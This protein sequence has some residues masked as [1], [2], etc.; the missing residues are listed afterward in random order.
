MSYILSKYNCFKIYDNTVV[1]L[2]LF[3]KMLFA[4]HIDKYNKLIFYGQTLEK[5]QMEEPIFFSAMCKLGMVNDVK[6]DE[7]INKIMLLRNR[8]K[9]F[10]TESYRLMILP[11]LHCNFN[12]WYCYEEDRPKR[13]MN[14]TTVNST[15]KFI[16]NTIR[17]KSRFFLDWYGGEPLLCFDNILKPISEKTKELCDKNNVYLESQITTNG[18]LLHERMLPLFRDINTQAFQ[19][20]LNGTKEIHN[21]VRFQKNTTDSYDRIVNSIILLAEDLEPKK[22]ILRINFAKEYFDSITDIIESFPPFIR[23]K[24]MIYIRQIDQDFKNKVSFEEIVEKLTIFENAGFNVE[25]KTCGVIHTHS[26]ACIADKYSQSVINYDGRIFKCHAVNFEKGIEDGVLTKEGEI[27]WNE[28]LL[29]NK[30]SKATFDNEKCL[31][32]KFLPVCFGVCH[33]RILYPNNPKGWEQCC[34]INEIE[35][36]IYHIMDKFKNSQGTPTYMLEYTS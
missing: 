16:E 22:L 5:L 19:I 17:N 29:S 6:F 34:P 36:S 31:N 7:N 14:K 23:K 20:T 4:I 33:H 28:Q 26:Y 25:M 13:I 21:K 15:I 3:T 35:K 10:E 1:G 30:L 9:I 12:C 32:C 24:I 27:E 8:K 2:N 11:T 18:Y